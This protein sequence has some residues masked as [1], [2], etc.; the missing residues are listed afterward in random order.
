MSRTHDTEHC[1]QKCGSGEPCD[2]SRCPMPTGHS[3]RQVVDLMFAIPRE[4]VTEAG[5]LAVRIVKRGPEHSAVRLQLDDL[6]TRF[7][8]A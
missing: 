5:K 3:E 2:T 8:D 4:P 7:K 6:M 1:L